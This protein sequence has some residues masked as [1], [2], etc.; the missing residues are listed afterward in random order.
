MPSPPGSPSPRRIRNDGQ[1]SV[2]NLNPEGDDD[3]GDITAA[4]SPPP[5]SRPTEAT[6]LSPGNVNEEHVSS[7]VSPPQWRSGPLSPGARILTPS[8][9]IQSHSTF[10][11]PNYPSPRRQAESNHTLSPPR[12]PRT[13]SS[14]SSRPHIST[15]DPSPP[16]RPAELFRKPSIPASVPISTTGD[17]ETVRD[18]GEGGAFESIPLETTPPRPSLTAPLPSSPSTSKDGKR[19]SWNGFAAAR[20]DKS[21]RSSWINGA[22]ASNGLQGDDPYSST[23]KSLSTEHVISEENEAGSSTKGENG[24]SSVPKPRIH[25]PPAHPHPFPLPSTTSPLAT[26]NKRL[27]TTLQ[28]PE[29]T[30]SAGPSGGIG[31]KGVSAFEKVMNHTRPSH[32]PPKPKDE[33]DTHYHQWEAMMAQAREHEKERRRIQD[34]RRL[35]KEKKLAAATP[36]W[37]TLLNDPGFSVGKVRSDKGLREMWFQGVPGYLRGKAWGLAIGNPLALSKGMCFVKFKLMCRCLQDLSISCE[38][39]P[40]LGSIP[41]FDTPADRA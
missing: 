22:P 25:A 15:P 4:G 17:V 18:G 35:E 9:S 12:S 1:Q 27:P 30:P 13:P 14:E 8:P 39:S 19:R 11:S 32:L 10:V 5:R 29:Q 28:P 23:T 6:R 38:E 31:A 34:A 7:S 40:R 37:D 41:R 21:K 2:L 20:G 36:I 26:A 33:D 16:K 24:E 3:H